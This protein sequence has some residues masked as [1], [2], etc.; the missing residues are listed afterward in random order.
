MKDFFMKDLA[1]LIEKQTIIKL[2]K[3]VNIKKTKYKY[4]K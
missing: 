4:I 3:N 2:I 1:G